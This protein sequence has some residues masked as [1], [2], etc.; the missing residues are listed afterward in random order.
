MTE[1]NPPL[2]MRAVVR[3]TQFLCPR[4]G[5]KFIF[6]KKTAPQ[7]IFNAT[8]KGILA[9]LVCPMCEAIVQVWTAGETYHEL[10]QGNVT[11]KR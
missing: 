4:C 2:K 6:D 3:L 1:N 7:A 8:E 9:T 5:R 10:E 11:V